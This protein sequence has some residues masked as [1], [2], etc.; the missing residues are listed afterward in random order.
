LSASGAIPNVEL[1][2]ACVASACAN[3]LDDCIGFCGAKPAVHNNVEP[4]ARKLQRNRPPI[5]RSS[6][7]RAL[8]RRWYS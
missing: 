4:I 2:Q 1:K 5:P 8:S 7:S 3:L 6:P